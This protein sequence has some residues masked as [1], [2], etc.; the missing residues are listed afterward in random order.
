MSKQLTPS[1]QE[2]PQTKSQMKGR[3]KLSN[4]GCGGLWRE[5]GSGRNS[6]PLIVMIK[7]MLKCV[8]SPSLEGMWGSQSW[9]EMVFEHCLWHFRNNRYLC[10]RG[11]L[12]GNAGC[13]L[14]LSLFSPLLCLSPDTPPNAKTTRGINNSCWTLLYRVSETER[15]YCS[16]YVCTSLILAV[17][18]CV[19]FVTVESIPVTLQWLCSETNIIMT[20]ILKMNS[21]H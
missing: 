16:V 5:W 21:S 17:C 2:R 14:V 19:W 13:A 7:P 18:V 4:R 6:F 12:C 8:F 11:H 9:V 15:V 1:T 20:V 3:Q 10:C